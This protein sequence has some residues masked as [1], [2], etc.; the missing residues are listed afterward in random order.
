VA[1]IVG[2]VILPWNLL[3][4][5]NSFTSYLSAY[6][7]FLSSIAGVMVRTASIGLS[8][9]SRTRLTQTKRRTSSSRSQ[10]TSSSE[11]ATTAFRTY[12]TLAAAVGTITR[13][14]LT[15]G[16]SVYLRIGSLIRFPYWP[17]LELSLLKRFS[18]QRVCRIYRR[19][20]HQRRRL[21]GGQYVTFSPRGPTTDCPQLVS[22]FPLPPRVSIKWLSSPGLACR[23]SYI[24]GSA[25]HSPHPAASSISRRSIS[26]RVNRQAA[27][28]R[29]G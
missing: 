19:H 24:T 3:K 8:F 11:G 22:R 17:N 21:R 7:V 12:T 23:R 4:D 29:K 27:S 5:S 9:S 14:A 25:W 2:F 16:S 15:F 28:T 6:S 26:L 20:P 10:N 18:S 1:A 13:L